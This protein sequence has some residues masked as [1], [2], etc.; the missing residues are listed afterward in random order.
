MEL[1]L[2]GGF[3]VVVGDLLVRGGAGGGVVGF[4]VVCDAVRLT[5]PRCT[6]IFYVGD[7]TL[8]F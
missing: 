5:G 2:R 3:G 1:P 4:G 6:R 8:V 7:I